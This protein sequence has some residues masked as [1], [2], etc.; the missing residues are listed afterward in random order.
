[1]Q[2]GKGRRQASRKVSEGCGGPCF[3]SNARA[4]GQLLRE[5]SCRVA[6]EPKNR[7]ALLFLAISALVK[8]CFRN[9]R[10][11]HLNN[12]LPANASVQRACILRGFRALF[13]WLILALVC[14]FC[15]EF[16]RNSNERPD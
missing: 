13:C 10:Y 3:M 11:R 9:A 8:A 4:T 2:A 6:L 14:G 7:P 1:M 15:S 16:E 12:L 5:L